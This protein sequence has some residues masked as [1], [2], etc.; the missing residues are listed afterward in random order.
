M[1][2][3]SPLG[4]IFN[5]G[6][7]ILVLQPAFNSVK[8]GFI[9]R[10]FLYKFVSSSFLF[11]NCPLHTIVVLFKLS[12]KNFFKISF[13]DVSYLFFKSSPALSWISILLIF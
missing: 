6:I 3:R 2:Y 7:W 13:A 11:S 8:L 9:S 12:P 5:A 4:A 1:K 10:N